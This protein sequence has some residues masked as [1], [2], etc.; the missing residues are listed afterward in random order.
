MPHGFQANQ[1]GRS[2]KKPLTWLSALVVSRGYNVPSGGGAGFCETVNKDL[3]EIIPGGQYWEE[4][5]RLSYETAD[6][7]LPWFVHPFEVPTFRVDFR[8]LVTA[9]GLLMDYLNGRLCSTHVEYKDGRL[10]FDAKR[11]V[12]DRGSPDAFLTLVKERLESE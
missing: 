12:E 10:F 9:K 3:I 4:V 7:P 5:A 1:Q 8:G 2:C 11:F 6:S